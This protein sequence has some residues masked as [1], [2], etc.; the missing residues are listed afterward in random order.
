[1]KTL[2]RHLLHFSL[3]IF[4]L[5][6]TPV[7]AL[8]SSDGGCTETDG[9]WTCTGDVIVVTG[10]SDTF[11]CRKN[12]ANCLPPPPPPPPGGGE[13]GG[14]G[15]GHGIDVKDRETSLENQLRSMDCA[16]LKEQE[17]L[18]ASYVNIEN[19]IL[20]QQKQNLTEAEGQIGSDF[21]S[22]KELDS[23]EQIKNLSCSTYDMSK[24][25]RLNKPRECIE[26]PGKPPICRTPSPSAGELQQLQQC[27]SDQRDLS[28]RQNGLAEWK[29]RKAAAEAGVQKWTASA[30]H[31]KSMLSKIRAEMRRK[32]C[33][34]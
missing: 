23:L 30:N 11:G 14:A 26:R 19:Q 3:L 10:S 16:D 4:A 28:T 15:P 6:S 18:Y 25:A 21:Y 13:S 34:S 27:R 22:Q 29:N 31:T 20:A 32:K 24:Q 5:V 2:F 8:D 17:S 7:Q 33:T 1:M 12:P 9:S